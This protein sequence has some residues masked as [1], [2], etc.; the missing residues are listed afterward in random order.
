MAG[1]GE[2][3]SVFQIKST[4]TVSLLMIT[5]SIAVINAVGGQVRQALTSTS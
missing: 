1:I 5:D 3:I 4:D 2:W